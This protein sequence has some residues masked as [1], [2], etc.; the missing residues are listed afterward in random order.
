MRFTSFGTLMVGCCLLAEHVAA[1]HDSKWSLAKFT[2]GPEK[3]EYP[4]KEKVGRHKI[5]FEAIAQKGE[6]GSFSCTLHI[7]RRNPISF[8]VALSAGK[9]NL[10]QAA[11]GPV[12][13]VVKD[14]SPGVVETAKAFEDALNK[15]DEW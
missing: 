12:T 9:S 2:T 14:T 5:K 11:L 7:D 6:A 8:N 3:A 4:F 10:L 15:V 1:I 13:S